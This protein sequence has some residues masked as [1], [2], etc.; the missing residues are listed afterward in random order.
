MNL[1]AWKLQASEGY[2][3]SKPINTKITDLLHVDDLKVF[4]A[5]EVKLKVVLREVQAAMGDIGLI[6]KK[7]EVHGGKCKARMLTGIGARFEDW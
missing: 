6:W 1:I 3:L 5:L 7:E 4:A 2:R